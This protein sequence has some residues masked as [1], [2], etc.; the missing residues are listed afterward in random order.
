M[1][2][3]NMKAVEVAAKIKNR[4]VSCVE[5]MQMITDKITQKDKE[6]RGFISFDTEGALKQA[7]Q[8]QK[9]IDEEKISSPLAGIPIAVKDNIC[10]KDFKTTCA[11]NILKDFRPSYDAEVISR[12]KTAGVIIVGKTNMDEFAMGST[13]ENSAFYKTV[14]PIDHRYVPG[15][16]SGGSAAVVGSGQVSLAL[17][18]DTG[19][20]IRQPAAFCGITGLKPT[21]G[22]VSRYGLVA[23]GSSLEQIGPMGKSAK[24]V[25][26]LLDII[27]GYDSKD[28]TSV[29]RKTD[30]L[31]SMKG[32][33]K[34]IKIAI[35]VNVL[36]GVNEEI[37]NH[38]KVAAKALREKGAIVEEVKID[39]W[40]Y[41]IP[42][43]YIIA[44]AEAGSN[45][46]RYDG[47]KYGYRAD[48]YKGLHQMYKKTRS[49]GFGDEVKRRIMLGS[50]VL[51]SGYYD[52][53]YLKALKVRRLI[54]EA[55]KK[56]F[57]NYQVI[58]MPVTP[59]KPWKIDEVQ[60]NS[61][62][63]Y[64]SDIFTIGANLTG[65]PAISVPFSKYENGMSGA[66]QFMA[67]YFD[68]S[69]ILKVAEHIEK[70]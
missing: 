34:G 16:S 39:M 20:S 63:V 40:D 64:D 12:L 25:A 58:M 37:K 9:L 46:S 26:A 5:M 52:E 29:K 70:L 14:N 15:G 13:T 67:D 17:G 33:I 50:Y 65:M 27:S 31:N 53:Y 48:D 10:T 1:D 8:V 54:T 47:V 3:L 38:I 62:K 23:Y 28:S 11:S 4:E 51:S 57:E 45:L 59:V 66:I 55:F 42:A 21:Y 30:F 60:A 22:T 44:S 6:I 24:D 43:Y 41:M 7:E 19:G 69:S 18:S 68:E 61:F 2:L 36:E 35:P 49:E 32:D 56:I